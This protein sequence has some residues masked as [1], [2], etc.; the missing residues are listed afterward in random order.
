[1]QEISLSPS[2]SQNVYVT[3]GGQNCAIKLHQ[4][5]T[6]FYADLYVDDKPIF[7]GVLCLNCV[8]LVRYK[9]LGFSGDLVFVDSKG[10]ADPYYDEI[11]TRFKLYYATSSEVG[12]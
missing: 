8:Y 5:S 1:M 11:G 2:L 4:R 7:Q 6:G 12:R 3:L 9:Y 10:T